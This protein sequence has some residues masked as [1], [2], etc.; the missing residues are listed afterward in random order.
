LGLGGR[1]KALGDLFTDR[2]IPPV[3][4]AGWPV[5][6][7]SADGEILWV[8]GIQPAQRARITAQTAQILHLQWERSESR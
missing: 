6:G 1:H 2:K 4:R 8:C 3:L 5:I 7:D